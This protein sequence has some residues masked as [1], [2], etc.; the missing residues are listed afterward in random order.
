MVSPEDAAL[1][2]WADAVH[3]LY[4]QAK[5]FA[6]PKAKQRRNAQ[7]RME[8]QLLIL[9]RPFLQDPSAPQRKL[10]QRMERFCK[11]LFVFVADPAVP[12]DNNAVERSLQHLV[13]SRKICGGTRSAQGTDSKMTLTSLFGTWRA[14][15]RNPLLECRALLAP[16]Q[17]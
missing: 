5:D 7:L 9:C 14:R 4:T 12:A 2:R 1:A 16:P 13:V 8:H 3:Q 17:L 6:H 15:G 11:G 10:C